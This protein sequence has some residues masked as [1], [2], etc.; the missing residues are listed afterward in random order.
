MIAFLFVGLA[1]GLCDI[2]IIVG[3]RRR[4]NAGVQFLL[5][6]FGGKGRHCEHSSCSTAANSTKMNERRKEVL[7]RSGSHSDE[8]EKDKRETKGR[9]CWSEAMATNGL[10]AG[11]T[12]PASSIGGLAWS[13]CSIVQLAWG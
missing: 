8:L 9:C 13:P 6:L 4:V 10:Y 2:A 3:M 5:G 12:G 1:P 7:W 11:D